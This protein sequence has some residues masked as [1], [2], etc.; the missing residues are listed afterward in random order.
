MRCASAQDL[1]TAAIPAFR[2]NSWSTGAPAFDVGRSRTP[3]HLP[4]VELSDAAP[5]RISRVRVFVLRCRFAPPIDP[6]QTY[7]TG[8]VVQPTTPGPILGMRHQI[9][10]HRI[11]VHVVQ[12]FRQYS[13]DCRAYVWFM[14][15]KLNSELPKRS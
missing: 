12:L 11:Q 1:L 3:P 7:G 8:R 13:G 10:V 9:S 5:L 2:L 14:E 6:D 15:V 4:G